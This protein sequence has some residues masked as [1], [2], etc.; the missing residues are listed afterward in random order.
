MSELTNLQE[1]RKPWNFGRANLDWNPDLHPRDRLGRFR[2]VFKSVLNMEQGSMKDLEDV[3]NDAPNIE[4]ATVWRTPAGWE[5]RTQTKT[6]SFGYLITEGHLEKNRHA[7]EDALKAINASPELTEDPRKF[8]KAM[9]K[10]GTPGRRGRILGETI[11]DII[12][13]FVG[14]RAYPRVPSKVWFHSITDAVRNDEPRFIYWDTVGKQY[15]VG[16]D[17]YLQGDESKDFNP[18]MDGTL[19]L[20]GVSTDRGQ[21]KHID[22]RAAR[23]L[24]EKDQYDWQPT[25]DSETFVSADGKYIKRGDII[26]DADSGEVV[27]QD[28]LDAESED[29]QIAEILSGTDTAY[30]EPP[31]EIDPEAEKPKPKRKTK[32]ERK[33]QAGRSK[34]LEQALRAIV[35]GKKSEPDKQAIAAPMEIARRNREDR[36]AES[37]EEPVEQSQT[38]PVSEPKQKYPKQPKRLSATEIKFQ[39]PTDEEPWLFRATDDRWAIIDISKHPTLRVDYPSSPG[40]QRFWVMRRKRTGKMERW[41]S[42]FNG[43]SAI[44]AVKRQLDDEDAKKEARKLQRAAEAE[45]QD[46]N[47]DKVHARL[48]K[49]RMAAR[50]A[51]EGRPS[52]PG[53]EKASEAPDTPEV[54]GEAP[55]EAPETPTDATPTPPTT[56]D[57]GAATGELMWKRGEAKR[58]GPAKYDVF[59]ATDDRG[60]KYV[61]DVF[62]GDG[63]ISPSWGTLSYVDDQG[64]VEVLDTKINPKDGRSYT[65]GN[66]GKTYKQIADSHRLSKSKPESELAKAEDVNPDDAFNGPMPKVPGGEGPA[67]AEAAYQYKVAQDIKAEL[68]DAEAPVEAPPPLAPM[69]SDVKKTA[70]SRLM[71][72]IRVTENAGANEAERIKEIVSPYS[73]SQAK[74]KY[75]NKISA[76][77]VRNANGIWTEL[78]VGRKITRWG[79][80]GKKHNG[81]L[82]EDGELLWDS[83]GNIDDELQAAVD[84]YNESIKVPDGYN[85]KRNPATQKWHVQA[86]NIE[87]DLGEYDKYADA[88]AAAKKHKSEDVPSDEVVGDDSS[89]PV[90]EDKP[91]LDSGNE[92]WEKQFRDGWRIAFV[93]DEQDL[94]TT[95]DWSNNGRGAQDGMGGFVTIKTKDNPEQGTRTYTILRNSETGNPWA[96]NIRDLSWRPPKK[97][98][99]RSGKWTKLDEYDVPISNMDEARAADEDARKRVLDHVRRMHAA[100]L[101]INLSEDDKP[102]SVEEA[103]E[104]EI[105]A[106]P[107]VVKEVEEPEFNWK[108]LGDISNAFES[109]DGSYRLM[110]TLDGRNWDVVDAKTNEVLVR[111]PTRGSAEKEFAKRVRDKTPEVTKPKDIEAADA[112]EEERLVPVKLSNENIWLAI[113]DA[114]REAGKKKK[115]VYLWFDMHE[116]P[117]FKEESE[118]KRKNKFGEE[119]DLDVEDSAGVA[120]GFQMGTELPTGHGLRGIARVEDRKG[121]GKDGEKAKIELFGDIAVPDN[122]KDEEGN[123]LY[124][125]KVTDRLNSPFA[126]EQID[127]LIDE[128]GVIFPREITEVQEVAAAKRHGK[129]REILG[130]LGYDRVQERVM[131]DMNRTL[132]SIVYQ[133]S[134]KDFSKRLDSFDRDSSPGEALDL[135]D[136]M[137]FTG[138]V[139]SARL[140]KNRTGTYSL[141]IDTPEG[142]K[143]VS[144]AYKPT[145]TWIHQQIAWHD[146]GEAPTPLVLNDKKL[147]KAVR[148][149]KLSMTHEAN[150]WTNL[151]GNQIFEYLESEMGVSPGSTDFT[152]NFVVTDVADGSFGFITHTETGSVIQIDR[153]LF[154][155]DSST[156]IWAKENGLDM[157]Y[158]MLHTLV[159]ESIHGLSMRNSADM[160]W[161]V[162]GNLGV[163]EGLADAYAFHMMPKVAERIGLDPKRAAQQADR[164]KTLT[165]YGKFVDSY[166]G[167]RKTLGMTPDQFYPMVARTPVHQREEMLRNLGEQLPTPKER[168]HFKN[169]VLGRNFGVMR[170]SGRDPRGMDAAEPEGTGSGFGNLPKVPGGEGPAE[171]LQ[172]FYDNMEME[173]RAE[174]EDAAA[175]RA[176][177]VRRW[178]EFN[179]VRV[180]GGEGP[181]EDALLQAE[182]EASEYIFGT[183]DDDWAKELRSGLGSDRLNDIRI[184][185]MNR[186]EEVRKNWKKNPNPK[187]PGGEG[188]SEDLWAQM[189]QEAS[190]YI[191]GTIADDWAETLAEKQ[192]GY[193]TPNK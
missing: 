155:P 50:K 104:P 6:G 138:R 46:F 115:P 166:E 119:Y 72:A 137:A 117:A 71:H 181:S 164:M 156:G 148:R 43:E 93:P 145:S 192:M 96:I 29:S 178:F 20:R 109:E 118:A 47:F 114:L 2:D 61:I 108:P 68:E 74:S 144:T 16:D 44:S 57:I 36:K 152:R 52:L 51:D 167:I 168:T 60:G 90:V 53:D 22:D 174:I 80:D 9:W 139:Q 45:G 82:P 99:E 171:D 59:S 124:D 132:S 70:L 67:E 33:E 49:E 102:D 76:K 149:K 111:R 31:A 165:S 27:D 116:D 87:G 150:Q 140:Y 121:G 100:E 91:E 21:Y 175:E 131:R 12:S 135:T 153:S 10:A 11:D 127:G 162:Y 73:S 40:S 86:D 77:M 101:G 88:V 55:E 65:Q 141:R 159:H 13:D 81:K 8:R 191:W 180:P 169:V 17:L 54:T 189:E 185:A 129:W 188:P 89:S 134:E 126:A 66:S 193:I 39:A 163:E 18:N 187:A 75:Q 179:N 97:F 105:Q 14:E 143:S 176:D 130:S 177:E 123:N 85:I 63:E 146:M 62:D 78:T 125:I 7:F 56:E 30:V 107:E 83:A 64:V 5:I 1:A 183:I 35:D 113:D 160:E 190:E 170:G 151:R 154:D 95:V 112:I 142:T 122:L 92:Y 161:V 110:K 25:D 23:K 24:R 147:Q 4:R 133:A 58:D 26:A 3:V 34:E 103:L 128:T 120:I 28:A 15:I 106:L 48:L 32:E 42:F 79:P 172:R 69:N 94:P 38:D 37:V 19:I 84:E 186:A 157:E 158:L 182:Q 136:H 41:G 184:G 98:G 173:Y